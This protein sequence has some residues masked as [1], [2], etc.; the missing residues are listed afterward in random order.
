MPTALE[1]FRAAPLQFV[2]LPSVRIAYRSFGSG[3]TLVLVHGWPLS[4]ETYR[5]LVETLRDDF[6]CIVPDLPGAGHT[7]WDDSIDE[8]FTGYAERLTGFVDAL[9]LQNFGLIG[10]DSGGAVARLLAARMPHRVFGLGLTNTEVPGHV[11]T[12]VRALQI[13]AHLPGA[14]WMFGRLVRSRAYLRSTFGFA[15]CFRDLDE[16]HGSFDATAVAALRRDTGPA[17]TV[18]RKANL[19]I[20]EEL[21]EIHAQIDAPM[22]A[23]WG[24]ED[25]FFPYDGAAAMVD[26]WPH[27]AVLHRMPGYRLLVHEEA[28]S[29]V[30]QLM[31]P[32]LLKAASEAASRRLSA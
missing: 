31:R 11:P 23:V 27:E 3:P 18:L 13:A 29:E 9:G 32:F 21:D 20:P 1:A 26:S 15:G 4:G 12:V 7:A 8:T 17:M 28:A 2:D 30:A 25:P 24:D 5:D 6:T 16:I 14:Q 10:H 19:S 22:I